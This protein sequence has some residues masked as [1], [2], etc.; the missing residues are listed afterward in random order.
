MR[1]IE[2]DAVELCNTGTAGFQSAHHA[3]R[4]VTLGLRVGECLVDDR[5]L[6]GMDRGLGAKTIAARRV[7]LARKRLG[8]AE[9]GEHRIDRQHAGGP[10]RQQA[11]TAR[12]RERRGIGTRS[13]RGWR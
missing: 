3:L 12:Q 4:P 1:R 7:S 6:G 10:R 8:I 13:N 5:D 11:E 2:H 9:V